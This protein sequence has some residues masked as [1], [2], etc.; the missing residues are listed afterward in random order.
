MKTRLLRFGAAVVAVV[1]PVVALALLSPKLF[2][3]GAHALSDHPY[4][5][6]QLVWAREALAAGTN[7]LGWAPRVWGG[8]PD[9]QFYP[10][11]FTLVGA[12]L[13]RLFGLDDESAYH[14]L[15]ILVYLLPAAS[16]AVCLLAL[17]ARP[18]VAALGGFLAGYLAFG[19]SGTIS[20][21][22]YGTVAS[23][24]SLGLAPLAVAALVVVARRAPDRRLL[25]TPLAAALVAA[26]A[27]SHPY[28]LLPTAVVGLAVTY[29][30]TRRDGWLR[31]WIVLVAGFSLAGVWWVGQLLYADLAAPFL[32]ANLEWRA[33]LRPIFA[34]PWDWWLLVGATV[35][36]AG[37][38]FRRRSE[39][40]F[41]LYRALPLLLALVAFVKVVVVDVAAVHVLDPLRLADDLFLWTALASPLVL[42]ALVRMLPGVPWLRIAVAV[43]VAPLALGWVAAERPLVQPDRLY[44]LRLGA[45]DQFGVR[46]LA[47]D[48]EG[49]QGRVLF[50][51]STAF[52]GSV[53]VGAYIAWLAQ[54][55]YLGGTST[56]PAPLQPIL[57]YGPGATEVRDL[58]NY[59]DDRSLFGIA[60]ADAIDD[61]EARGRLVGHLRALGVTQVVAERGPGGEPTDPV[62]FAEAH[63]EVLAPDAEAGNFRVY[64]VVDARPG[65]I[66]VVDGEAT[67]LTAEETTVRTRA[68]VSVPERADVRLRYLASPYWTV[69]VD[70]R[71]VQPAVDELRQFRLDLPEGVHEV[72]LTV[73]TPTGV[74]VGAPLAVVLGAALTAA[75]IAVRWPRRL[76][77]WIDA[78]R[79][80]DIAT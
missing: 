23:R 52:G 15:T 75:A 38:S 47:A 64:R 66:A 56:H 30:R 43:S 42:E 13:G 48:L 50:V 51:S 28:H 22:G 68:Q 40:P 4:R 41:V 49:E 5:F 25:L 34:R 67:V 2:D 26:V 7:P 14:W 44:A 80:A 59:F 27:V 10:P 60:W 37:L 33:L 73:R 71:R 39:E 77:R 8:Y 63:P 24:L 58:A 46:E 9:L 11:G 55:E 65:R 20:G 18:A 19:V 69:E 79:P 6:T 61:P 29:D 78:G 21:T 36:G 12:G 53:H 45:L 76:Q 62:R 17:R 54:R 3:R 70:G 31:T 16:G 1:A 72:V 74:K 35:V 32:W 57:L